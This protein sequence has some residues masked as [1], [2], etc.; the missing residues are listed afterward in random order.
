M[1]RSREEGRK[2]AQKC[3]EATKRRRRRKILKKTL[4]SGLPDMKI[5]ALN[6]DCLWLPVNS[7]YDV[8]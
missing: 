6:V 4:Q 8:F 1:D 3:L 2:E 5:K 7:Q